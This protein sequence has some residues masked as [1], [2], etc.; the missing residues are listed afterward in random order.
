MSQSI[1][2]TYKNG[3]VSLDRLPEGVTEARVVVD[4]VDEPG[5]GQRRGVLKFGMFAK[6]DRPFTRDE[7]ID[8]VKK[9]WNR[10]DE[11]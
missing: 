9:S 2:G 5:R 8:A 3:T 7:D 6:P 10:R 1:H 4:F 11:E